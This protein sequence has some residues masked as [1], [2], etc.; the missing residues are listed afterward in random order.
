MKLE[1]ILKKIE[2]GK[3]EA[4]IVAAA[5][6]AGIISASLVIK[7]AS[8]S[9]LEEV[10]KESYNI[11]NDLKSLIKE[12]MKAYKKY[13]KAYKSGNEGKA[14]E[15]LKKAV[16]IPA[17]I[18]EQSYRIIELAETA[19]DKGKK[20]MMLESYGAATIGK[21]AINSAYEI[22]DMNIKGLKDSKYKEAVKQ[23]A[24]E[25]RTKA[26]TKETH[27]HIILSEYIFKK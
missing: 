14:E 16:E 7:V 18:L 2:S 17:R 10:E 11:K 5:A 15:Y 27:M 20:S 9:G 19:M 6:T 25:L 13:L 26:K 3:P 24:Y 1:N 23:R 12:D 21:A 8:K 4:G 22:I